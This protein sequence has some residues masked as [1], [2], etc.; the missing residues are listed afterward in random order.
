VTHEL[1]A[2]FDADRSQ[3]GR[4]LLTKL[5]AAHPDEYPDTLLRTLQRRLKG[6]RAEIAREL[7]FGI[8]PGASERM[9]ADPLRYGEAPRISG[10]QD[11]SHVPFP[12]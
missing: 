6:W 1:R 12:N 10:H 11:Q 9:A 3:T 5:Q 4:D 8:T 2:W 7:V